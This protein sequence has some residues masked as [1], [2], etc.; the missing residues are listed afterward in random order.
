MKLQYILPVVLTTFGLWTAQAQDSDKNLN[1]EMLLEKDY[2]PTIM[3]ASRINNLPEIREPQIRKPQVEYSNY[4][5]PLSLAPRLQVLDAVPLFT[6]VAE[7]D[8]KGYAN[9]GIATN[10]NIDG[11]LGYQ[12]LNT[13]K[14]QLGI[15][16]SHRSSN[17]DV[18]YLQEDEKQKMKL[19]DTWG[20]VSFAHKLNEF[21]L[22]T[23][24]KYTHSGF[25]YYGHNKPFET[26][27]DLDKDV[28]QSNNI[29]DFNLGLATNGEE[30]WN[31]TTQFSY[32]YF[33]QK[34]ATS[35]EMD[36]PAE[37]SGKFDFDVN[38]RFSEEHKYGLKGFIQGFSYNADQPDNGVY[39]N[40][41]KGHGRIG[42]SPYLSFS[43]VSWKAH[44]GFKTF[45]TFNYG[46]TFA[47]APDLAF[48]IYP[49]KDSEL[50]LRADGGLTSNSNYAVYRI[51]RY[52]APEN[53]IND[54]RT[55][56]DGTFGYKMNIKG[57]LWFDLYA[58]YRIDRD[59][60][61][62]RYAQPN[63]AF[64]NTAI[65]GNVAAADRMDANV[66]KVGIQVKYQYQNDFDFGIKLQ[67]NTWDVDNYDY[68]GSIKSKAWNRP[69]LEADLTAGYHFWFP[70]RLDL[71]YHI[72]AGRT[73]LLENQGVEQSL[74]MKD[75]NDLNLTATYA[76]NSYLSV[77]GKFNNILS[78][79]YDLWYGYPAQKANF[80]VGV[81][82]KF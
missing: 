35:E 74:K 50:Y 47:F 68:Q 79:D 41:Y 43:D 42:F 11:D 9:F 55:N 13:P 27:I 53:R 18:T 75:I 82:V 30:E 38:Y 34:Y 12:I 71:L 10:I 46:K 26:P 20:A 1:R 3:K 59:A 76:V 16:L 61:F 8:K 65:A 21:N 23:G 66:F 48:S 73:T 44:I 60:Y 28:N 19:N 67:H 51:N 64:L 57:N 37:S 32:Y 22:F 24:F 29:V 58:G 17:S 77:Y 15:Y 70:L 63:T 4:A 78:Q 80:M 36:G 72:E 69:D 2:V 25:N 40:G 33:K 7:S 81:T 62:F 14:N 45:I 31:F 52:A 49:T 6:Q 54:T 56:L 5:L 39:Y